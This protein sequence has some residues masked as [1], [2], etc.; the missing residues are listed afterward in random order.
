MKTNK[1]NSSGRLRFWPLELLAGIVIFA[2]A[3][4][5]SVNSDMKLTETHL[6]DVAT[7]I[8]NQCHS[9]SRLNLA[10]ESK[11][12]M[13]IMQSV[14]GI[15]REIVYDGM[16]EENAWDTGA[17]EQYVRENYVTGV[18]MLDAEGKLQGEYYTDDLGAKGLEEYLKVGTLL[19][20]ASFPEKTYSV[21]VLCEDDSYVDM[22]ACGRT[23]NDGI[24]VAYYHT[25]QEYVK[26]FFSFCSGA[27]ERLQYRK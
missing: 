3:C 12:L 4:F 14:R 5:C 17:L 15:D 16:Q 10:S 1:K 23:G 7:Y 11:S 22:A 9:Y 24:I 25:P 26:S 27:S 6:K 18:I 13:R 2:G 19:E 21:R 8:K 20:T